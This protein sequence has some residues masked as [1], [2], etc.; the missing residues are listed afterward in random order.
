LFKMIFFKKTMS[1]DSISGLQVK[2]PLEMQNE[3]NKSVLL[4]LQHE[5]E[6]IQQSLNGMSPV[7]QVIGLSPGIVENILPVLFP[8]ITFISKIDNLDCI[9]VHATMIVGSEQ[10]Q[11]HTTWNL[12]LDEYK[13][14]AAD[15]ESLNNSFRDQDNIVLQAMQWLVRHQAELF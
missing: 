4:G 6:L 12:H 3:Q 13:S 1:Y 7:V 2:S 15:S 9:G 11:C 14:V 8:S 5:L 10:S